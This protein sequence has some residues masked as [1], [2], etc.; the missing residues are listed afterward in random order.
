MNVAKILSALLLTYSTV[1]VASQPL[2]FR[3]PAPVIVTDPTGVPGDSTQDPTPSS[4]VSES[5]I[6]FGDILVGQTQTAGV[7]LT[8]NGKVD[9][10]V[11]Q[12]TVTGPFSAAYACPTTL[13]PDQSCQI[14]VTYQPVSAGIGSGT[15]RVPNTGGARTVQLVGKAEVYALAIDPPALAFGYSGAGAPAQRSLLVENRGTLPLALS[16]AVNP[17]SSGFSDGGGCPS[18]LSAGMSCSETVLF[19]SATPGAA[20]GTVSVGAPGAQTQTSNLSAWV[21]QPKIAFSA[22]GSNVTSL[23]FGSNL[24]QGK[25][26]PATLTVTNATQVAVPLSSPT[27][28]GPFSLTATDCPASLAGGASC[29]ATIS[30]TPTYSASDSGNFSYQMPANG[31]ATG[32]WSVALSGSGKA[33]LAFDTTSPTASVQSAQKIS[34]SGNAT[35]LNVGAR[36]SG[37]AKFTAFSTPAAT[38]SG[39]MYAEM[40]STTSRAWMG[41]YSNGAAYSMAMDGPGCN[42]GT[43]GYVASCT[44]QSTSSGARIGVLVDLGARTVTLSVNGKSVYTNAFTGAAPWLL[45]ADDGGSSVDTAAHSYTLYTAPSTWRFAPANV[46]PFQ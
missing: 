41:A 31:D 26:F 17:P 12:P 25:S 8:N 30:Y 23:N 44:G 20:S 4:S 40:T 21:Q 3:L 9:I 37:A 5:Q 10:T 29:S 18:S 46:V 45:E 7:A 27:V 43:A 39:R 32:P 33:V 14:N 15:L 42:R 38:T 13:S 28:T 2:V 6:D 19:S 24:A 22:N 36:T 11:G 35:V 1:T 16:F 34:Y